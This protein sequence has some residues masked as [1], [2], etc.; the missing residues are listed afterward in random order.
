MAVDNGLIFDVGMH[1]GE[2]TEFYLRKGFRVVAVEAVPEF[3]QLVARRLQRYVA[4]GQLVVENVA[5]AE[6]AGPVSFYTSENPVWG[7]I[8][9]DWARRNERLGAA[10]TGVMTVPA[11][12]FAALLAAHGVPHYLKI[13]IEGADLLCL[14]ALAG[15]DEKPPYVS[16]ESTKTSW[17][18]LWHEFDLF[19]RLGYDR[20][21][22]VS[23]VT[24]RSQVSPDPPREGRYAEHAFEYG[25][26]GLFGAE[27][28]G[29]WLT[30]RQARIRYAPVF[31]RYRL[32]GDD[33]LFRRGPGIRGFAGWK[34]QR[35]FGDPGWYD[36]HAAIA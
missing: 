8:R 15:F 36:T 6:E 14:E 5:I 35:L 12:T 30:R 26:S 31:L 4:A 34:L 16:I 11:V 24:V 22:V 29:R 25:A 28:P 32:Y 33:G 9:A 17:R 2:D 13:D 20:F 19:G 21:K 10:T 27:L 18:A 1:H 3:C 7:T 23:Q